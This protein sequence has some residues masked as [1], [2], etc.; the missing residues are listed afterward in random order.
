MLWTLKQDALLRMCPQQKRAPRDGRRGLEA[1]IERELEEYVVPST[2]AEVYWGGG[3]NVRC[4]SCLS[5]ESYF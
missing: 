4:L 2:E 5:S 1:K 3:D